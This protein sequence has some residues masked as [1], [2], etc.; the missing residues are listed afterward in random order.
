[1]RKTLIPWKVLQSDIM[2]RKWPYKDLILLCACV[3]MYVFVQN[4]FEQ[5]FRCHWHLN[6][7]VGLSSILGIKRSSNQRWWWECWKTRKYFNH[8]LEQAKDWNQTLD[9]SKC[10]QN[11]TSTVLILIVSLVVKH[12]YLIKKNFYIVA[13]ILTQ[14]YKEFWYNI[15]YHIFYYDHG[16]MQ[17][18]HIS[19]SASYDS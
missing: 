17:L 9:C 11:L 5:R 2:S 14:K 19:T 10:D 4:F 13:C 12:W 18:W 8:F 6:W 1:M 7:Y 3:S 15:L 16:E